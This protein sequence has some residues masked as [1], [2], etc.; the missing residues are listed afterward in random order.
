MAEYDVLGT[1]L[2]GKEPETNK[3]QGTSGRAGITDML[4]DSSR[5]LW[6]VLQCLLQ[7]ERPQHSVLASLGGLTIGPF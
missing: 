4:R 7:T 2:R 3:S 5:T 1:V 6:K